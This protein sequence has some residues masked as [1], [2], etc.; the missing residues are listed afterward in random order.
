MNL[1]GEVGGAPNSLVAPAAAV[2]TPSSSWGVSELVIINNTT[3]TT[4]SGTS[5]PPRAAV[6]IV[7]DGGN[8]ELPSLSG[9]VGTGVV[10][11]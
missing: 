10:V 4:K 7:P 11:G 9:A 6:P 3:A 1:F 2:R 8:P 5:T